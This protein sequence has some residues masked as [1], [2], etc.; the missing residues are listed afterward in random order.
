MEAIIKAML[1]KYQSW[2]SN[3][4]RLKSGYAYEKSFT[5]MWYSL[6]HEIYQQSIGKVPQSKNGK[7]NFRPIGVK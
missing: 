2:E 7:K 5:E 4:E 1:G 6:G 3:P